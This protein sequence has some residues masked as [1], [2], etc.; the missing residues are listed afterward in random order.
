MRHLSAVV[1]FSGEPLETS[2]GHG[3]S[4]GRS[5]QKADGG[6]TT[7]TKKEEGELVSIPL[8][9]PIDVGYNPLLPMA[10]MNVLLPP[11]HPTAMQIGDAL[12]LHGDWIGS[13]AIANLTAEPGQTRR[14]SHVAVV[15]AIGQIPLVIESVPPRVCVAPMDIVCAKARAGVLLHSLNLSDSDRETIVRKALQF[16]GRPYGIHQYPFLLLD[17]LFQTDVFGDIPLGRLFPVCSALLGYAYA[18]VNRYW[19]DRPSG[20]T[21]NEAYFF[22]EKGHPEFFQMFDLTPKGQLLSTSSHA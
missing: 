3:P 4:S 17:A 2:E 13:D 6:E 14:F 10:E 11:A 9:A 22:A 15:V 19:G 12:V 18:A 16:E 20:L 5:V 8:L 1:S 21:P 7:T